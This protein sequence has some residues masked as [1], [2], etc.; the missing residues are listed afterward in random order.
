MGPPGYIYTAEVLT[1]NGYEG[2]KIGMT[3]RTPMERYREH[4]TSGDFHRFSPMNSWPVPNVRFVERLIKKTMSTASIATAPGFTEVFTP[5]VNPEI[6]AECLVHVANGRQD[7][8]QRLQA[9]YNRLHPAEYLGSPWPNR[10]QTG[11]ASQIAESPFLQN[12]KEQGFAWLT[13]I[14]AIFGF[15]FAANSLSFAYSALTKHGIS[16]FAGMAWLALAA[17]PIA[18]CIFIW[19]YGMK[20]ANDIEGDG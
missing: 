18:T 8:Y 20:L 6:V 7:E 2:V 5:T 12:Q 1:W 9:K 16:I 13:A 17:I 4:K 15:I 10:Q 19:H 14:T 3:T 11:Q